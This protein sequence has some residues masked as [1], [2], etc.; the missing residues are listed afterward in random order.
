MKKIYINKLID[1]L[2]RLTSYL[3]M[4]EPWHII[5]RWLDAVRPM[6]LQDP[7]RVCN[8]RSIIMKQQ[9][10]NTE[11]SITNDIWSSY[12]TYPAWIYTST[13]SRSTE[14]QAWMTTLYFEFNNN[15][16]NQEEFSVN[17]MNG[18]LKKVLLWQRMC[19]ERGWLSCSLGRGKEW[20]P[21]CST[22]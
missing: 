18:R 22:E 4:P 9:T 12:G 14:I 10:E 6:P 11:G 5:Q 3:I 8:N 15:K 21:G 20:A 17:L 7:H 13:A 1:W 2:K 19:E 16:I